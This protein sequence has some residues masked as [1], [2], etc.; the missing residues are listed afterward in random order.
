MRITR[1]VCERCRSCAAPLA[2]RAGLRWCF[3]KTPVREH[4]RLFFGEAGDLEKGLCVL[5]DGTDDERITLAVADRLSVGGRFWIGECGTSRFMC[6]ISPILSSSFRR[7][8]MKSGAIA[9]AAHNMV[10]GNCFSVALK[11]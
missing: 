8:R 6:R 3:E 4:M 2:A 7:L 9:S 11:S 1:E 5:A 10:C